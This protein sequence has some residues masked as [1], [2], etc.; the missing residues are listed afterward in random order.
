MNSAGQV[1]TSDFTCKLCFKGFI[2]TSLNRGT[3]TPKCYSPYFGDP[4]NGTLN[5]GKP[6]YGPCQKGSFKADAT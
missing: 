3:P 1:I 6:P 5:F 2:V 4:Q